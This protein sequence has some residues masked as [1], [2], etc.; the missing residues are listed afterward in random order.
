MDRYLT[1]LAIVLVA[2]ILALTCVWVV[3][4]ERFAMAMSLTALALSLHHL[5]RTFWDDF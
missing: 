5:A 4:P 3:A 2:L 1:F